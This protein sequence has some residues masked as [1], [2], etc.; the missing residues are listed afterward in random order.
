LETVDILFVDDDL[1]AIRMACLIFE[2]A[3]IGVVTASNGEEAL[4][5]FSYY[6]FKV[7]ISDIKM[8]RMDGFELL[9]KVCELNPYISRV[10]LSGHPDVAFIL[11][12]VN[13]KGI[14]KYL[15]KPLDG[16]DLILASNQCIELYDLRKEVHGWHR[17]S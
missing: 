9:E 15:T 10:V 3:D 7:I 5:L 12:L 16:T 6:D 4:K 13:E 11:K 17:K 8:R 2:K 14:D 1:K